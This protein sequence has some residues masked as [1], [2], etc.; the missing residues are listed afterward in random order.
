[1]DEQDEIRDLVSNLRSLGGAQHRLGSA[2]RLADLMRHQSEVTF[3][4]DILQELIDEVL[5]FES[6]VEV[7]NA[8]FDVIERSW[9]LSID[10]SLD[11]FMPYVGDD[12]VALLAMA[13]LLMPRCGD[14]KYLPFVQEHLTH[15]NE[16][17]R[18]NA[19]YAWRHAY[20]RIANR[21]GGEP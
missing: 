14:L 19:E 20:E 4:T 8:V 3:V 9:K 17:V 21:G 16:I 10:P 6:D 18:Q 15:E 12:D 13:L 2:N 11:K 7:R 1:M 5:V